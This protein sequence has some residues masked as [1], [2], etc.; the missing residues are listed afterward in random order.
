MKKVFSFEK[1]R[2]FPVIGIIRGHSHG[3]IEETVRIAHEEGIRTLEITMNTPNA[4]VIIEKLRLRYDGKLN[5]GAGTVRDIDELN[6]AL[7]AGAQFI[8]TP[9][10]VLKVVEKCVDLQV[11]IFAGA[12]TPTEIHYA[13]TLGVSAV[14]LFPANIGGLKYYQSI[15][16]PLDQI[17]LI[18]TGGVTAGNMNAYL[19]AGAYALGMGS[20][21]FPSDLIIAEQWEEVRKSIREVVETYKLWKKAP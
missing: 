9:T 19:A 4:A 10:T 7:S 17:P 6:S 11:P 1:L 5:I 3:N 12:F 14:K 15:R 13:Y 21:L 2:E 20:S 16:A 8:V 18:P